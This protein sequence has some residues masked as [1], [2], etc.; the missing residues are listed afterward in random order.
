MSRD[1]TSGNLT[2]LFISADDGATFENLGCVYTFPDIDYGKHT[3][4]KDYCVSSDEPFISLGQL[5]F[6]EISV[7]YAWTEDAAAAGNDL[8]RAAHTAITQTDKTVK[9]KVELN[10]TPDG[11]TSP[12][13][14]EIPAIITSYKH[15]NI[16]KDGVIKTMITLEQTAV[17]TATAAV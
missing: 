13:I 17:P 5:E 1:G 8:A 14:Y 16:V 11:G 9:I 6:G 3:S 7:E 12:T 2:K 10:N 15:T 4:N